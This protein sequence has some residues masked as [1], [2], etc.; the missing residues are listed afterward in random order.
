[1]RLPVIVVQL[2]RGVLILVCTV[3]V[4]STQVL[5]HM[6]DVNVN[7]EMINILHYVVEVQQHIPDYYGAYLPTYS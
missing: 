7:P 1:M 5:V 4:R 6:T 3:Q 2:H